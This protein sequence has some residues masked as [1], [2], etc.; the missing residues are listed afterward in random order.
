MEESNV[1]KFDN[2]MPQ[3][4]LDK[5]QDLQCDI[6]TM[7]VDIETALPRHRNYSLVITKLEE[8]KHWLRD[9]QHKPAGG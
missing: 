4:E 6:G 9:R 5:V 3:G 2:G 8:A 7:I 1:H